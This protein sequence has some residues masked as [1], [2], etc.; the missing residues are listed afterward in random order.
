M[1]TWKLAILS[2]A[3]LAL[4]VWGCSAGSSNHAAAAGSGGGGA[5][6]AASTTTGTGAGDDG[7][8]FLDGGGDGSGCD[9]H[10][11]GDLHQ[12][13]DCNDQVVTTCPAGQG[14]AAGACV[15]A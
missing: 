11:S 2:S 7:G 10:C 9:V 3:S 13:L 1:E 15:M 8:L 5:G 4:A 6:G 14:C 12:V